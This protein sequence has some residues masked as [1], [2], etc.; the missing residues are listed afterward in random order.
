[1]PEINGRPYSFA[2]LALSANRTRYY[3]VKAASFKHGMSR[4]EQRGTAQ[5]VL[6][7]TRG[8]Y[9]PE[10][11]F[12]LGLSDAWAFKADLGDG[13]M[14]KQF[15]VTLTFGSDDGTDMHVVNYDGKLKEDAFDGSNTTEAMTQKFPIDVIGRIKEDGRDPLGAGVA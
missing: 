10:A 15:H 1:M 5:G 2:S 4:G 6:N 8:Q 12:E 3:E 13:W 14:N 9:K 11:S 7:L